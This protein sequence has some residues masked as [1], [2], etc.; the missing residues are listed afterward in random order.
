[1]QDQNIY[2]Y[3]FFFFLA[4]LPTWS[5]DVKFLRATFRRSISSLWR[6]SQSSRN[7]LQSHA[8]KNPVGM[9]PSMETNPSR[10]SL[11][12]GHVNVGMI[13]ASYTLYL[14]GWFLV[15]V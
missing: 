6:R 15:Y 9:G 10:T 13:M 11:Q 2:S 8:G 5:R 4:S 12:K 14:G 3:H 1:M 7:P